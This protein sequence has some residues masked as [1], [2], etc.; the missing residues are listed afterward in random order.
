MPTPSSRRWASISRAIRL[1]AAKAALSRIN[2]ANMFQV[3]WSLRA[4][5]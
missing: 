2:T 1:K 5:A 3:F 4:S